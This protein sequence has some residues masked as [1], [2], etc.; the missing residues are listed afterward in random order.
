MSKYTTEDIWIYVY[1]RGEVRGRELE[2][3]F[4][5]TGKMARK[6]MYKYKKLLEAEGKLKAKPV[7]NQSPPYNTYYVPEKFHQEAEALR[8]QQQLIFEIRKWPLQEQIET[9]KNLIEE[10]KRLRR[11]KRIMDL[12]QMPFPLVVLK[13]MVGEDEAKA[14]TN[15]F[16]DSRT[17]E[18][19][20]PELRN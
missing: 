7:P 20:P 11:E 16:E 9:I 14:Y 5:D 4:V 12:D 10:V 2:A 8:Q 6:T 18:D 15:V 3:Q 13:E 19:I 1:E 17:I